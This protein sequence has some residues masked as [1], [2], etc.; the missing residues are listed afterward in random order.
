MKRC[1]RCNS[2]LQD[3]STNCGVC[4]SPLSSGP[5]AFPPQT[6]AEI[7]R[8][9]LS[10]QSEPRGESL[11]VLTTEEVHSHKAYIVIIGT[12][13]IAV[14][15]L[16]AFVAIDRTSTFSSPNSHPNPYPV[17]MARI[18]RNWSGFIVCC[19]ASSV[20]DVIGSWT[21]PKVTCSAQS[22]ST[23]LADAWVGIDGA[24]N[25]SNTV[26]QI[27]TAST[28]NPGNSTAVYYAWYEWYPALP[29]RLNAAYP[30]VPGDIVTAEVNWDGSRFT[31]SIRDQSEYW[32]VERMNSTIASIASRASAEWILEAP[33]NSTTLSTIPLANFGKVFF[34]N[35]SA[36]VGAGS[37]PMGTFQL[38][39]D[40]M[41]D[42]SS[43]IKAV[44]MLPFYNDGTSFSVWWVSSG[45]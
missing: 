36:T 25:A 28:C 22:I 18:S 29:R 38:I 16:S 34:E 26:E 13:L 1:P 24:R 40:T 8:P 17:S 30:I 39:Q 33:T 20:T 5:S 21:V 27:G 10:S 45:P 7:S 43:Y 31:A 2:L 15:V 32:S 11:P 19:N 9:L 41:V 37:G 4:G 42:S 14:V 44:P 35:C 6:Q 3:D 23:Q 12:L